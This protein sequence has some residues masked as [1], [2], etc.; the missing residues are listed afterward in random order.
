MN[1]RTFMTLCG[2]VVTTLLLFNST[3]LLYA[4][5]EADTPAHPQAQTVIQE[6]E[7]AEGIAPAAGE[8][9]T[10][11]LVFNV[12]RLVTTDDRGFPRNDPPMPE[13]NGNWYSPVN[14]AEGTFYYR[15]EIR[16]QPRPQEMRLQ[17]CIWQYS[18]RLENCGSQQPVTGTAGTVVTWEQ[19]VQDLWKKDGKLIDWKNPR[20]RYGVAI[21]NTQKKPV[22]NYNGWNW[23]GENPNHWYP[24]DMR[25]TV[26]VV[27]KGATFSGWA[28]YIDAP[29]D[30]APDEPAPDEG[31]DDEGVPTEEL[32]VFQF[33]PFVNKP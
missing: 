27:A 18:F 11:L 20:Q 28:T 19:G 8:A 5:Q 17:F 24:L 6:S 33:L 9:V 22:S 13:A 21:K 29:D 16:N 3:L 4:Q 7:S 31:A 23:N 15:V 12:N 26:V 25:F 14:F 10:E 1:L 32:V 30:P 2:V